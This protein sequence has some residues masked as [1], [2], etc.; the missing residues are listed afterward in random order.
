MERHAATIDARILASDEARCPEQL[1]RHFKAFADIQPEVWHSLAGADIT[2]RS[3]G[4]GTVAGVKTLFG[5][6]RFQ[7][8]FGSRPNSD[9]TKTF[10]AERLAEQSFLRMRLTAAVPG[11]DEYCSRALMEERLKDEAAKLAESEAQVRQE[12]RSRKAAARIESA[13]AALKAQP[14]QESAA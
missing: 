11:F 6:T 9:D 13:A 2:H 14:A 1:C 3:F 7:A 12:K 4:E 5:N 10:S 8:D